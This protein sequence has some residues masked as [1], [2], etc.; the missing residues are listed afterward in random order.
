MI[1]CSG[2]RGRA[3]ALTRRNTSTVSRKLKSRERP[4]VSL[5]W[6]TLGADVSETPCS[7]RTCSAVGE[8]TPKKVNSSAL[9]SLVLRYSVRALFSWFKVIKIDPIPRYP[10][11]SDSPRSISY[12][13][14]LFRTIAAPD[15][16]TIAK[17]DSVH[18]GYATNLFFPNLYMRT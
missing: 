13:F 6:M 14:T 18:S 5:Y 3:G 4:G 15:C 1:T 10:N 16:H 7:P 9:V 12:S 2:S 8:C 17:P 11:S